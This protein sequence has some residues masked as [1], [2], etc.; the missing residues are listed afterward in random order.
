MLQEHER[1]F[2]YLEKSNNK[3]IENFMKYFF[4]STLCALVLVFVGCTNA[5]K[6]LQKGR[7]DDAIE[8]SIKVLNKK[9]SDAKHLEVLKTAYSLADLND[10]E[11]I[12][13]LKKSGQPDIWAQVVSIYE[14]MIER[15]KRME[16]LPSSVK[17]TIEFSYRS[18]NDELSAAKRKAA[19]YHYASGIQKLEKGTRN[20]ARS[21]Y[22]DF[23]R[24]EKYAGTAYK[25]VE[26]FKDKARAMGTVYVLYNVENATGRHLSAPMV[27]NLGDI[28][29]DYLNSFWV[30]YAYA[31]HSPNDPSSQG[32]TNV[33]HHY[34]ATF[35]LED[36]LIS[37]VV[38]KT[39]Q[40]SY[41]QTITDGK[42]YLK[43]AKGKPVLDS[44]GRFIEI[45]KKRTLTC[46]V[47][48]ITQSK[49]VRVG[50]TLAYYDVEKKRWMRAFPLDYRVVLSSSMYDVKG[51]KRALDKDLRKHVEAP[52]AAL[53]TDEAMLIM[54]TEELGDKI[55]YRMKSY[56]DML[57]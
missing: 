51:D 46:N 38:V 41:S 15:N 37:P 30:H 56:N 8:K 50:G 35:T 49:E 9:P 40:K 22:S 17:N 16:S 42:E 28:H 25:D 29:P 7:Y 24:V 10:D 47:V 1:I 53:P 14:R 55:R 43:D 5:S 3:S 19:D 6:A 13:E 36:L 39:Q 52:V 48:E 57:E 2:R 44:A 27:Y 45:P 33:S 32:N 20:D 54:A 12:S 23:D 34:T 21:A 26:K 4:L 11:R 18:Y 31:E